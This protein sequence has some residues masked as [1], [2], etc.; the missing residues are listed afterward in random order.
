MKV[1][2]SIRPQHA[3][4]AS[5]WFRSVMVGVWMPMGM[6]IGVGPLILAQPASAAQLT[7]KEVKAS[8]SAPETMGVVFSGANTIDAKVGSAW[9][10]GEAAAGLGEWIEYRFDGEVTLNRIEL[11]NGNWYSR[12]YYDRHNRIKLVQIKYSNGTTERWEVPDKMERQVLTLKAPVK[13]R[14]VRFVL[15]EVFPGNT[16]NDTYLSEMLFFGPDPGPQLE[17]IKSKASSNL[18]PDGGSS[19]GPEKLTDGL[20]DTPWCEGK[21][22]AGVGESITFT[23]PGA[24]ALKELRLL[25]G[26]AVTADTYQKNGRPTKLKVEVDGK[27]GTEISLPDTFELWHTIPLDGQKVSSVKLTVL[28]ATSGTQYNDTCMSEIQW[29]VATP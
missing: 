26:V 10:E 27:P 3:R 12:E 9:C 14:S 25:N 20:V 13:T 5:D 11:Y 22:D 19:Y 17:G 21:K 7:V 28:E 18:P 23:L 2:R 16:F 6:L 15:K 1:V 4:V 8:S 24:T 29:M